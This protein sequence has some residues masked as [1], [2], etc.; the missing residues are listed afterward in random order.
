MLTAVDLYQ[1]PLLGHTPASEA[2]L[3]RAAAAGTADAGFDQDAPHRGTAQ[4]D[5]L[6]LPQ[7]FGEVGVV[8]PRIAV[9]GQPYYRS[10]S[11]VMDGIAGPTASVPVSQCGGT[12]F[13]VG[14]EET[15]GMTFAYSHNPGSLGDGKVVFQNAVEHLNPCL[16]LLIQRY[17]PHGDDMG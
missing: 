3:R 1:H 8:C 10:R 5:A 16:F 15:L 11:S 14:R 12:V 13:A 9:A 7:Q 17:I 4:V 6:A 2:V